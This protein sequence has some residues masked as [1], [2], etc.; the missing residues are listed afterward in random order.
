MMGI[1]CPTLELDQATTGLTSTTS[2]YSGLSLSSRMLD[3]L[4]LM[5]MD[6]IGDAEF[7]LDGNVGTLTM[8][9]LK[10]EHLIRETT[11]L[12]LVEMLMTT[13]TINVTMETM[14]LEMDVIPH[15]RSSSG[16][17]VKEEE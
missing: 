1:T 17:S 11:A 7:N 14:L 15:V 5:L 6:V 2:S 12:R 9:I 8:L 13:D 10:A 16:M 3:E 4:T